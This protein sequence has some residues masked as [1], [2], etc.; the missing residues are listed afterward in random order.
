MK[1]VRHEVGPVECNCYILSDENTNEGVIIDAGG[2][3]DLIVSSIDGL[4]IK[5]ILCTHGHF[6]HLSGLTPLRQTLS[7]PISIHENDKELYENMQ[8]QAGMFGMELS[9]NPTINHFLSEDEELSFGCYKIKV[10]HTPGHTQGGVCFLI[11]GKLFS[12]DTL[13]EESIGRTDLPGGSL[14]QLLKSVKEKLL[15]LP[16]D[17]VVYPGH[18]EQTSIKHEKEYNPY[19]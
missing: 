8:I 3:A 10:I 15:T 13:F 14:Q 11:D 4:N 2:D 7:A 6:D 5:H 9:Q 1:I 19:F 12:G 18:G 16:D 17:T